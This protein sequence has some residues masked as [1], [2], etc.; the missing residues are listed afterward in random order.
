MQLLKWSKRDASTEDSWIFLW[1]AT[2]ACGGTDSFSCFDYYFIHP[3]SLTFLIHSSML[4]ISLFTDG[5]F[6]FKGSISISLREVWKI[7][8]KNGK[9]RNEDIPSYLFSYSFKCSTT[10]S[11]FSNSLRKV[12]YC[13]RVLEMIFSLSNM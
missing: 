6:E 4:S 12:N 13:F 10:S 5:D 2:R 1:S 3:Y 11:G 7:G 8:Q 9:R